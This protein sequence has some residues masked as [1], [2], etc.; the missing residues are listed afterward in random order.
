MAPEERIAFG[1]EYMAEFL[2]AHPPV[3]ESA[4]IGNRSVSNPAPMS[5]WAAK[6]Q[7]KEEKYA[8]K[9]ERKAEKY[10]RKAA[11]HAERV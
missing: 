9:V 2:G 1:R 4:E 10:A 5:R 11:R 6:L 7:R 8:R 3:G